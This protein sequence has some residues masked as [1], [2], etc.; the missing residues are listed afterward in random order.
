MISPKKPTDIPDMEYLIHYKG[1]PV[2]VHF[3]NPCDCDTRCCYH[4]DQLEAKKK[5]VL[6]EI[7]NKMTAGMR[8]NRFSTTGSQHW[9]AK[10]K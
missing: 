5:R 9:W 3:D 4:A 7:R 2:Y 6:E 8:M 1:N 10:D